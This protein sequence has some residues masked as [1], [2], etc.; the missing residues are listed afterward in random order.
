MRGEGSNGAMASHGTLVSCP[1]S[2][3]EEDSTLGGYNAVIW[4]YLFHS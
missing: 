1:S 4:Q 3:Q 2:A